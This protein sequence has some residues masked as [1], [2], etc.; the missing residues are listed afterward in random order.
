MPHILRSAQ[1]LRMQET[2][3]RKG[4]TYATVVPD[5]MGPPDPTLQHPYHANPA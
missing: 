4:C 3:Q 5:Y 1:K 2:C